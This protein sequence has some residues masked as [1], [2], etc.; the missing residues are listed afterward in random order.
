MIHNGPPHGSNAG[1]A[2][3][4]RMIDVQNRCYADQHG[5][6][7]TSVVPTN[8]FGPHDNFSIDDG[9]V[10]PGLMHKVYKAKRLARSSGSQANHHQE[11][12]REEKMNDK[13]S[14]VPPLDNNGQHGGCCP[15]LN[16]RTVASTA[17]VMFDRFNVILDGKATSVDTPGPAGMTPLYWATYNGYA[18]VAKVLIVDGKARWSVRRHDALGWQS[19]PPLGPTPKF[20]P[21]L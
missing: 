5:C 21:R 11:L 4:K 12:E 15:D 8:I 10:L 20:P 1:Y 7:W 18:D 9:H 3:A 13:C 16:W 14:Q 19:L 17:I 6:K 2:Y